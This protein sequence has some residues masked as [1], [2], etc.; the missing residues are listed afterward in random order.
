MAY[1]GRLRPKG[2]PLCEISP[3]RDLEKCQ[4]FSKGYEACVKRGSLYVYGNACY[5]GYS[6]SPA[7]EITEALAFTEC[8]LNLCE[9]ARKCRCEHNLGRWP[10]IIMGDTDGKR[11][12]TQQNEPEEQL[13]KSD[14]R[15]TFQGHE[16]QIDSV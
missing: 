10:T 1:T 4:A 16:I 9:K 7:N 3:S 8:K 11:C 5:V 12:A 14:Y 13:R 6:K 15:E 2:V